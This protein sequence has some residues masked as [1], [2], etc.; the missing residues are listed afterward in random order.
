MVLRFEGVRSC[1]GALCA[2]GAT[3]WEVGRGALDCGRDLKPCVEAME[4]IISFCTCV[5]WTGCREVGD[6]TPGEARE[7]CGERTWVN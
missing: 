1:C 6:K 5:Q 7:R 2:G 3:E 4:S